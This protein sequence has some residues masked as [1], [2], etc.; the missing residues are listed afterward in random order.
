[1]KTTDAQFLKD[2][3]IQPCEIP[4]PKRPAA[5][6]EPRVTEPWHVEAEVNED[7]DVVMSREEFAAMVAANHGLMEGVERLDRA[8]YRA[9][10][11]GT[12]VL[13]MAAALAGWN[14]GYLLRKVL[15][16]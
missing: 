10:R 9:R 16:G 6:T 13:W 11:R 15:L 12:R 2:L 8:L 4:E 5:S 3:R 1:M 7:G 14:L